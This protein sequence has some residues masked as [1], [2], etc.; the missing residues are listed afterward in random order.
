MDRFAQELGGMMKAAPTL[1]MVIAEYVPVSFAPDTKS[2]LERVECDSG[3]EPGAIREA[4]YIKKPE[5][6]AQGQRVAHVMVGFTSPEQANLAIRNGLVIEGKRVA[7]RRHRMDPKRCMKCQGIGVSHNAADCKFIHDVC[8]RCAGMHRTDQCQVSETANL[9]C[10]N[11]KAS[12][13]GAADRACPVFKEKARMLHA[14]IPNYEYRFFPTTDPHT[15]EKDSALQ[16]TPTQ[17]VTNE[18]H[19]AL[20]NNGGAR[21]RPT[22]N[23]DPGQRTTDNG[24]TQRNRSQRA[25]APAPRPGGTQGPSGDDRLKQAKV[26]D[27]FAKMGDNGVKGSTHGGPTWDGIGKDVLGFTRTADTWA[28]DLEDLYY[29]P[30]NINAQS[31]RPPL[32]A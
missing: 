20:D 14:K 8:A 22:R 9:K 27:M 16:T 24:W 31:P 15:W 21:T 10:A 30:P 6:R 4:R 11:C 29:A 28:D 1:C 2:A 32:N 12:G 13:H 17:V 23:R 26:S 5:R 18:N 19:N 3:L 25:P 7:I